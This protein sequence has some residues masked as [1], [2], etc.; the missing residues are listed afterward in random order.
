MIKA[1]ALKCFRQFVQVWTL[2]QY[3]SS[4][5]FAERAPPMTSIQE[6]DTPAALIDVPRMQR[7]I[8]RM[9]ERMNILSVRFS[10]ARQDGQ[11]PARCWGT[12]GSWRRGHHCFHPQGSRAV[13]R[14]GVFRHSVCRWHCAEQA[15]SGACPAK[16]RL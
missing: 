12:A 13:L 6:I 8:E 9:Q 10:P 3:I 1:S 11:V 4:I 5:T 2:C 15:F 16:A 14:G 7:N